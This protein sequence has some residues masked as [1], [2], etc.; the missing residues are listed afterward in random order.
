MAERITVNYETNT[1]TV[2]GVEL[3]CLPCDTPIVFER[4]QDGEPSVV[5]LRLTARDVETIGNPALPAVD[6]N[7][8]AVA[9]AT[10]RARLSLSI[11]DLP[12]I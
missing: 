7:V 1:V 2:D 11:A 4:R 5:V 12:Q 9:T 10:L 8:A 6:S 3:S